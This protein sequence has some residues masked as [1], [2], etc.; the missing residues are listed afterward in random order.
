MTTAD[1]FDKLEETAK[2]VE[3]V[4]KRANIKSENLSTACILVAVQLIAENERR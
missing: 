2:D 1:F 4:A 3:K